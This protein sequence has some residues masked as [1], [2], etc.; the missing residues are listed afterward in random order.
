LYY[1]GIDQQERVDSLLAFYSVSR[2]F[3]YVADRTAVTFTGDE[4][5]ASR[6]LVGLYRRSGVPIELGRFEGL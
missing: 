6:A 5:G 1:G 4:E 3:E 2:Q